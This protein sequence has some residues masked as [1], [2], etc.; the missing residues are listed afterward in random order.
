MLRLYC[1]TTVYIITEYQLVP[2]VACFIPRAAG[3]I[4][5]SNESVPGAITQDK[6]GGRHTATDNAP[7]MKQG[8]PI[9]AQMRPKRTVLKPD[10]RLD[11]TPPLPTLLTAST[12]PQPPLQ[13]NSELPP[14]LLCLKRSPTELFTRFAVLLPSLPTASP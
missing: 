6:V 13:P 3:A 10:A 1:S 2:I 7:Q 8:S 12:S 11:C 4:L 14:T 9:R 5:P